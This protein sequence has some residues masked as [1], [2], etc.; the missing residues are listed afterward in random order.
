[1]NWHHTSYTSTAISYG[2]REHPLPPF[3]P[4]VRIIG[5]VR[6]LRD[7]D[8]LAGRVVLEKV[9]INAGRVFNPYLTKLVQGRRA[10][11]MFQVAI[12]EY[13]QRHLGFLGVRMSSICFCLCVGGWG[14]K[15]KIKQRQNE[16]T[17]PFDFGETYPVRVVTM[18]VVVV[19]PQV[20]SRGSHTLHTPSRQ[21]GHVKLAGWVPRHPYVSA[22]LLDFAV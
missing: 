22:T 3:R 10:R 13:S 18:A 2:H 19:G 14:R 20:I 5:R 17:T 7:E 6:R 8:D 21:Y 15:K 12:V 9:R 4:V 16:D 1:V 11:D